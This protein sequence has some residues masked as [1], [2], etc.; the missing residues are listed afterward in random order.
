MKNGNKINK[1]FYCFLI[2]MFIFS[3]FLWAINNI[4]EE[5]PIEYKK[6]NSRIFYN[7]TNYKFNKKLNDILEFECDSNNLKIGLECLNKLKNYD[8][9]L[10]LVSYN[11]IN[12]KNNCDKCLVY[13]NNLKNETEQYIIYHHTFWQIK[14]FDPL[15][16]EFNLRTLNLNI[17]SYLTT[18]NLCCTRLLF[19]KLDEFP[20]QIE[21]YLRKTYSDYFLNETIQI[22]TFD[23]NELCNYE[24]SSFYNR[25]LC[26]YAT[27]IELSKSSLV[28]LSDLVRFIVLDIYGGI[29]TDGIVF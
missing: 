9:Q 26:K 29:Y 14:S 18:Q 22:K 2:L 1:K 4:F 27:N 17:M 23:L 20:V 15:K 8:N 16:D 28:S 24:I 3:F 10:N 13:L 5:E 21:K 19:W 7:F 25:K 11:N 12:N 6:I